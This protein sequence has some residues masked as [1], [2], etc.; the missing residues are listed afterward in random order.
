MPPEE[1]K[2]VPGAYGAQLITKKG[3]FGIVQGHQ[4]HLDIDPKTGALFVGVVLRAI[5]ASG[6]SLRPPFSA[7]I[8]MLA[9]FASGT[10]NPTALALHP[11]TGDLWAG[12]QERD[13]LGDQLPCAARRE[14]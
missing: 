4:R 9:T 14:V 1:R 10:R 6:P 8:P 11:Q 2:P 7:S 13:S 12:V 5:S 3:V